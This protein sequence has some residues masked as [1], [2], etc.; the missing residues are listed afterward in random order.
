MGVVAAVVAGLTL[1]EVATAVAVTGAVLGVVGAIT[2]DKTLQT[3]GMVMGIAGGVVGVGASLMGASAMTL[4][5]VTNLGTSAVSD[6]FSGGAAV[7]EQ[8]AL[9]GTEAASSSATSSATSALEGAGAKVANPLEQAT[10]SAVDARGIGTEFPST[11]MTTP[12]VGTSGTPIPANMTP[13][14][15]VGTPNTVGTPMASSAGQQAGSET[16]YDALNTSANA[17]PQAPAATS[18]GILNTQRNAFATAAGNMTD[19]ATKAKSMWDGMPDYVK[20]AAVTQGIGAIG[21]MAGG[22]MQGATANDQLELQKLI[23]QQAQNQLQYQ[24]A[25]NAFAPKISFNAPGILNR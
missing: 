2:K 22:Y 15:V 19:S 24:N 6:F 14:P 12:P 3:I 23:N 16:S 7:A 25:N 5:E 13:S 8:G 10:S 11:S 4:G 20:Y 17:A 21:S 1:A 9:A 18:P